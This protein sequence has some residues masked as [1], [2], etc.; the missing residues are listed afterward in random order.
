MFKVYD[1]CL[2]ALTSEAYDVPATKKERSESGDW[3]NLNKA[4]NDARERS[5]QSWLSLRNCIPSMINRNFENIKNATN[6]MSTL[7]TLSTP[8]ELSKDRRRIL[9]L[10]DFNSWCFKKAERLYTRC[11]SEKERRIQADDALW[12]DRMAEVRQACTEW[13]FLSAEARHESFDFAIPLLTDAV[14]K[15]QNFVNK[16]SS[17][18]ASGSVTAKSERNEWIES[19]NS[20]KANEELLFVLSNAADHGYQAETIRVKWEDWKRFDKL[21]DDVDGPKRADPSSVGEQD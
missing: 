15:T 3:T 12:Q 20:I 16:S 2:D 13:H 21:A 14:T 1:H 17:R 5:K 11:S 19:R 18:P 9:I 10:G 6:C 8:D 4:L 7:S